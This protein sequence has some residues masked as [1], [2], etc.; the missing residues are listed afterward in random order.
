MSEL[1]PRAADLAVDADPESFRSVQ[2]GWQPTL[3]AH[4]RVR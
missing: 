2:P 3:A 1:A 4:T